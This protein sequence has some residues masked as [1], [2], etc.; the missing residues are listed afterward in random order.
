MTNKSTL[1]PPPLCEEFSC[2]PIKIQQ[3]KEE[4]AATV[5][6]SK[7]FRSLADETRLK[8]IYALSKEELCVCDLASL[9]GCSVASAS[10]HLRLL[11]NLDLVSCRKEG[12]FAYYSMA[13]E[14]L[15]EIITAALK[16]IKEDHHER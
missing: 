10:H 5:G 7:V 12:K 8:I 15:R 3:L 9:A 13:D 6:L 14:C 1:P 11:Y 2:N 16:H 4:V